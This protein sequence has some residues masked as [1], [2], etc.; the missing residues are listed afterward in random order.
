LIGCRGGEQ[1]FLRQKRRIV[2]KWALS[3]GG[4]QPVD[5]TAAL[6]TRSV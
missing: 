4:G 5:G 6:V 1:L 3:F 2:A